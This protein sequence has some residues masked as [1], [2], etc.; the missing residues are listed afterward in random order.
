MDNKKIEPLNEQK[1]EIITPNEWYP[2]RN[3][4]GNHPYRRRI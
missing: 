3:V 2:R 4:P 1:E